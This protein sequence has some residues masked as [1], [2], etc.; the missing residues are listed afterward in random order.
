M[1]CGNI[2]IVCL[3]FH[4][5]QTCMHINVKGRRWRAFEIS[6]CIRSYHAKLTTTVRLWF[7]IVW[8]YI[9]TYVNVCSVYRWT[10]LRTKRRF[11]NREHSI[12]RDGVISCMEHT[13]FCVF[14]HVYAYVCFERCYQ[15]V[16]R[17][18]KLQHIPTTFKSIVNMYICT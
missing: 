4:W 2:F 10:G 11:T 14:M 15:R 1:T 8:S 5:L 7:E 9:Q 18:S 16:N 12:S 17:I 6:N 13:H 3:N